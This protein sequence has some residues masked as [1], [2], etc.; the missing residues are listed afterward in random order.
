MQLL[1]FLLLTAQQLPPIGVIKTVDSEAISK[2]LQRSIIQ[3]GGALA[4]SSGVINREQASFTA[5]MHQ[6]LPRTADAV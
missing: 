3:L 4:P 6:L 2:T 5:P 1:S